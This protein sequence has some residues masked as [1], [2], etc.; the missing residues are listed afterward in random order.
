MIFTSIIRDT[1]RDGEIQ[2]LELESIVS[3]AGDMGLGFTSELEY[4]PVERNG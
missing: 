4:N 1:D 2:E 3:P